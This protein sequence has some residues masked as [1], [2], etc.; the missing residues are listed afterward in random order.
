MNLNFLFASGKNP[1][2]PYYIKN[3]AKKLLPKF[4][5]QSRLEQKLNS[6]SSREDTKYIHSRV[7][8]YNKL[9]T[10]KELP[11]SSQQFSEFK[12]GKGVSSVF[13]LD[14]YA[15]IS[16][17]K[18]SFKWSFVPGDVTHIPDVPSIVKSRP[19]AGNIENSILLKLVKVRHFIFVRD[20]IKFGDKSNKLIFRGKIDGKPNRIA[21]MEKYFTHPMCDLGDITKNDKYPPEW[22]VEKTTI[23]DHL[24]F[25]FIL[26]LEGNDVASNLKWIMSS[27]S[28][29]VMPKPTYET[30]FME[31][32]LKANYHYIEIKDDFSDLEE[33][34][35]HYIDYP[36]QAIQIA[37]NA[38][39]Y[40][41]Q[42][43]DKKREHLIGLA[44]M[45]KYLEMTSQK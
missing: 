18:G 16:W 22:T 12:K 44:V 42:F 32:K 11:E 35:N 1:K 2:L 30:W 20:R 4:V 7:N 34:L 10:K 23:Y 31:G 6:I 21:F 14:A 45:N 26:A 29:A 37:K 27:N 41:S 36:E 40:V 8:Y 28:V 15:I 9:E 24:K 25:K 13:Y 39:D 38:N 3:Y 33:R 43:F 17:F 19:I 5:F